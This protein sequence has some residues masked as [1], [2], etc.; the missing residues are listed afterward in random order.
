MSPNRRL[1]AKLVA[2]GLGVHERAVWSRLA[3]DQRTGTEQ[4]SDQ[5][6]R[7]SATDRAAYADFRGNVTAVRRAR[8]AVLAGRITAAGPVSL[9]S[10]CPG[11]RRRPGGFKVVQDWD[12]LHDRRRAARAAAQLGQVSPGL[13]F[14]DSSIPASADSRVCPV[15]GLLVA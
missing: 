10:S 12:A 5:Q 9:T 4:G 15:G 6:F 11:G 13:E 7:L 14:G 1:N 3:S 8:T 2:A